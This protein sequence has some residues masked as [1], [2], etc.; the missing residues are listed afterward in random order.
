MFVQNYIG[1]DFTELEIV[2]LEETTAAT[3]KNTMVVC[4]V[5][6][7]LVSNYFMTLKHYSLRVYSLEINVFS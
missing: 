2:R 7:D 4:I 3:D 5:D 1:V 6:S